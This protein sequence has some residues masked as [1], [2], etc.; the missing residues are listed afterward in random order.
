MEPRKGQS[1]RWLTAQIGL[2][3]VA[4]EIDDAVASQKKRTEY[5]WTR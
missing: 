1:L 4:A 5:R 2:K 3:Y